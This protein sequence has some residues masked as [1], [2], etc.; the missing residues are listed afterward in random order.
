MNGNKKMSKLDGE[1]PSGYEVLFYKEWAGLAAG[2]NCVTETMISER[3]L[4]D[5]AAKAS[6]KRNEENE[7]IE[8]STL[9][10]RTEEEWVAAD[11]ANQF[12]DDAE[13]YQSFIKIGDKCTA[14]DKSNGCI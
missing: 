14:Q 11:K 3:N 7:N 6:R 9:V 8:D 13:Y 12:K 2:C 5:F 4:D 10:E 1:C